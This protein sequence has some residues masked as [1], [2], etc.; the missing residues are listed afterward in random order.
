LGTTKR[1]APAVEEIE[2]PA[3]KAAAKP[4]KKRRVQK[5]LNN[6][7]LLEHIALSKIAWEKAKNKCKN[8]DKM[9][10]AAQCMTPEMV[11]MIMM[12]VDRYA[13]RANWRGYTYIDDMKSEALL[14]LLNG[15]L[16]F[17]PEKSKNPFG[18]MTQIVTHSFLT[19][20]DKEKKVRRI[21][22]D[23]LEQYGLDPSNTRQIENEAP[24][25]DRR[26][27]MSNKQ[28]GIREI[29]VVKD[30]EDG[31]VTIQYGVVDVEGYDSV[32]HERNHALDADEEK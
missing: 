3:K 1:T 5:Y 19:T 32:F 25:L 10:S 15:S 27:H 20:L 2:A 24:M 30:V 11:K 8:P 13:Q 18:Y 17:N 23:I 22:D 7:R 14:S 29:E 16:K 4:V 12:L 26:Q 31:E 21:R 9:P 28:E 6:A